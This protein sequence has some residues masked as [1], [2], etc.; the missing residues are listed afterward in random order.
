MRRWL[1]RLWYRC[2]SRISILIIF[3]TSF[4]RTLSARLAWWYRLTCWSAATVIS[5]V[6]KIALAVFRKF[7]ARTSQMASTSAL[8]ATRSTHSTSKTGFYR[9]SS[10]TW[11]FNAPAS[12]SKSTPSANILRTSSAV[13]AMLA[14]N[15]PMTLSS[16]LRPTLA[17]H[18]SW[19]QVAHLP[20]GSPW[21][22]SSKGLSLTWVDTGTHDQ[23]FK[24]ST[25]CKK[26]RR[27][28]I[29]WT[30]GTRPFK[31]SKCNL[32]TIAVFRIISSVYRTRTRSS[33]TW[34]AEA[35]TRAIMRRCTRSMRSR[36]TTITNSLSAIRWSTRGMDILLAG[37]QRSS[38]WSPV[39]ERRRT[40]RKL[41][42]K[43]TIQI[44]IS[45]SKCPT[46]T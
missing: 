15:D 32:T 44:L 43:C 6:V 5:C 26:T 13:S 4:L 7:P 29:N 2:W 20:C 38:L 24:W 9:T 21:C 1:G 41:N 3:W 27:T 22:S 37:S 46:W 17:A 36:W 45:G 8:S 34:L 33:S 10:W 35:I 12:A 18:S 42:V 40:H 19:P 14:T 25:S 16:K 11:S 23:Q 31:P 28:F 30:L 39:R